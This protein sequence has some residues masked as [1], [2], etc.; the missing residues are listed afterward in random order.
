ME[1]LPEVSLAEAYAQSEEAVAALRHAR[2][3]RR[4]ANVDFFE[5][6]YQA[7]LVGIM[8]I[9]VVAG[10]SGLTGDKRL[11]AHQLVGVRHHGAAVVGA[12]IAIGVAVALRSGG[13]GGPLALE[14]ADVR[15]L[16]LSPVDRR[17]ALRGPAIQQLRFAT[18]AGSAVGAVAGLIAYHRLPGSP[19]WWVVV[20]ALTGAMGAAGALGAALAVSGARLPRWAANLI[21]VGVLAWSAADVW[22]GTTTS[23]VSLLGRVAIWPVGF[24]LAALVGVAVFAAVVGLGLRNVGGQ[25]L[26]ASETR[27]RLVGR[28]RFAATVRDVRTVMVLRRQLAQERPRSRPWVRLRP[29]PGAGLSRAIFKR[30]LQGILRWPARRVARL[31]VLG[32][33]AGL[34]MRAAWGGTK[35]LIVVAG[36]ALWV[37]ALD[38]V[39]PLAQEVDGADRLSSHPR[40]EGWIEVRHLGASCLVMLGVSLVS[41]AV[42]LPFGQPQVVASVGLATLVSAVPAAVAGGAISV[43]R[44]VSFGGSSFFMPEMTGA[45]LFLRELLPPAIAISGLIPV[46]LASTSSSR[47]QP[48]GAVAVN[49]AFLLFIIPLAAGAWV[50]SRGQRFGGEQATPNKGARGGRGASR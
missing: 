31:V 5:A 2:R 42:A 27:A 44:Q 15:H 9:I 17:L 36:L 13:R 10:G 25:S 21:A 19:V 41:I 46:L 23:P 43:V 8:A 48:A 38:A 26:E 20:G 7:Y 37:A 40:I 24:S 4:L 30:G 22:R 35:P 33:I 32:G 18:F 29:R 49:S 6:L 28:L 1:D 16:L 47:T 34:A 39:E 50:Q 3:R 12:A 11:S 14:A 45:G